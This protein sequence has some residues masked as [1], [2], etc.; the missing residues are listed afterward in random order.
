MFHGRANSMFYG[1]ALLTT[2]NPQVQA[3]RALMDKLDMRA[4]A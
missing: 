2:G 1:D 3:D 4:E